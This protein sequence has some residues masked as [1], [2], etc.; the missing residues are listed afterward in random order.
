MTRMS[1]V[2]RE[3]EGGVVSCRGGELEVP[4]ENLGRRLL[5]DLFCVFQR[6]RDSSPE[7]S[8][9]RSSDT[10]PPPR[11]FEP[12]TIKNKVKREEIARKLKKD[13]RQDKLKRRLALAKAESED[14]AAKK[15]SYL[16]QSTSLFVEKSAEFSWVVGCG[17][18]DDGSRT[19]RGHWTILVN[20]TPRSSPPTPPPLLQ[21]NHRPP[22]QT[23]LLR[24][25]RPK[26]RTS[27]PTTSTRTPS[28][29]TSRPPRPPRRRPRKSSSRPPRARRAARTTSARSSCA[30]S[31]AASSCG[32][33][34]GAGSRWAASRAG[35][36]GGGTA[37]WSW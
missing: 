5:L 9:V 14:P 21:T 34:A 2:R 30:C 16:S 15:V 7:H 22:P 37:I 8:S 3:R 33:G 32:A 28:P 35:R 12:S 26:P 25:P 31:R 24:L 27:P 23:P 10:M 18:R 17:C 13:K 4:W 19:S 11:R 29:P 36:R 6:I 1:R 20:T